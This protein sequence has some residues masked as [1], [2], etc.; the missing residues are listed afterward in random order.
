MKLASLLRYLPT[1]DEE[2]LTII[3]ELIAKTPIRARI[4]LR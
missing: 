1:P 3:E 4:C 2:Y